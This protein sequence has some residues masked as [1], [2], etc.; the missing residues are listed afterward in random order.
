M[1]GT[2]PTAAATLYTLIASIED[3]VKL[4]TILV[5]LFAAAVVVSG[6]ASS[7][8]RFGSSDYR[9]GSARSNE[10]YYGVIDSIESG[11]AAGAP[12]GREIGETNGR[13]DIYLIRVRFDDR[14]FQTVTQASLDG[15]GVGDSVRIERDRVRRY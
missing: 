13:Q 10:G 8:I 3:F 11:A 14:S 5:P 6:C 2:V 7:D 1:C 4:Q 9:Y 15:L 12:G